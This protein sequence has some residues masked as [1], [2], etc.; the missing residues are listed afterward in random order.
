MTEPDAVGGQTV[1]RRGRVVQRP[2]HA[3]IAPAEIVGEDEHDIGRRSGRPAP[4]DRN[5]ASRAAHSRR[6]SGSTLGVLEQPGKVDSLNPTA[7]T[8]MLLIDTALPIGDVV[9][10]V[11]AQC[12]AERLALVAGR[13]MDGPR[14]ARAVHVGQVSRT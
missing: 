2:V 9:S 13:G 1:Q 4:R 10:T 5:G 8:P 11:A 6:R 12:P 7:G 3:E 14:G